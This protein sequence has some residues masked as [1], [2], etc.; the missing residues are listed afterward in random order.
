M[1]KFCQLDTQAWVIWEDRRWLRNASIKLTGKSI[2]G[3]FSQ[4]KI[5]ELA[6]GS[7][8]PELVVLVAE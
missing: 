3:P 8:N 1:L 2:Y 5:D 7:A 4:L 6:V